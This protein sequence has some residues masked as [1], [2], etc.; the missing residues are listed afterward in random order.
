MREQSVSG[1]ESEEQV[2]ADPRV[3]EARGQGLVSS[4][5]ELVS[6]TGVAGVTW[7]LVVQRRTGVEGGPLWL[8]KG[9][10]G[11]D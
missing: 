10:F 2:P 1:E 3:S 4:R 9:C 6:M 8:L 5:V 11:V 7:V